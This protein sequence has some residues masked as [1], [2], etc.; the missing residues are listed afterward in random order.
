L[1]D[2]KND[3]YRFNVTGELSFEGDNAYLLD[4]KISANDI[5]KDSLLTREE[6]EATE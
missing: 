2:Q 6:E 5:R 1:T 3:R 4:A